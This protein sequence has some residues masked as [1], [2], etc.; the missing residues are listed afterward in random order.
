[1]ALAT[2]LIPLGVQLIPQIPVIVNGMLDIYEAFMKSDQVTP[3]Q[4]A[5]MIAELRALDARIQAD[6]LIV[7]PVEPDQTGGE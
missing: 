1:M 2:V 5:A 3:E 7:V 6:P 4:R